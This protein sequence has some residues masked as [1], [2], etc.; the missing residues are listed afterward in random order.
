MEDPAAHF[1]ATIGALPDSVALLRRHAPEAF[2]AYLAAREAAYRLPPEGHLPLASKE[3]V[4]IV[5]DVAAGHVEG[6][7][8]HAEAGLRAGLTPGQIMEALSIAILIHGHQCWA[9]AGAAVMRRVEQLTTA[10][11]GE[12]PHARPTR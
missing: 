6:A 2:A 10:T 12:S 4:F 3:L 5:L 9:R 8:A 7:V 11:E 1:E